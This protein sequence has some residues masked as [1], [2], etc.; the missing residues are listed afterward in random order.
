MLVSNKSFLAMPR[1]RQ[2]RLGAT[3]IVT[4]KVDVICG[5]GNESKWVHVKK[6]HIIARAGPDWIDPQTCV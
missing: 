6:G 3:A 2:W 5:L 4:S 1:S